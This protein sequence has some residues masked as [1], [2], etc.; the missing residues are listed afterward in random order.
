L[1]D[2]DY[3]FARQFLEEWAL[4][5]WIQTMNEEHGIVPSSATMFH[6]MQEDKLEGETNKIIGSKKNLKM[7][8]WRFRNKHQF[9]WGKLA[10]HSGGT[11]EQIR[12]KVRIRKPQNAVQ[13]L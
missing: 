9:W 11:V 13:N 12:D 2:I 4:G 8:A 1:P 10:V 3:L 7:W 5:R 6:K